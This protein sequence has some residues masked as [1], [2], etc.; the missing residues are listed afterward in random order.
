MKYEN[1]IELFQQK[2]VR[3]SEFPL[4]LKIFSLS[5]VGTASMKNRE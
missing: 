1:I 4:K 5:H 2:I 3:D